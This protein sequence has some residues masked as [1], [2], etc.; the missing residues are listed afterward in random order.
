[1]IVF[2]KAVVVV[3]VAAAVLV[4]ERSSL[5][6]VVIVFVSNA[7]AAGSYNS[8]VYN[9]YFPIFNS[10]F[11]VVIFTIPFVCPKHVLKLRTNRQTYRVIETLQVLSAPWS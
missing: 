9:I 8:V 3:V 4:A 1:M 6:F 2:V 10:I 5:S 7:L 11:F